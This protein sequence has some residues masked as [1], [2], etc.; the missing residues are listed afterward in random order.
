MP[1]R[2]LIQRSCRLWEWVIWGWMS[3]I[4]NSGRYIRN[5]HSECLIYISIVSWGGGGI[6]AFPSIP[7]MQYPCVTSNSLLSA[8]ANCKKESSWNL[9]DRKPRSEG[10]GMLFPRSLRVSSRSANADTIDSVAPGF[11]EDKPAPSI[12]SSQVGANGGYPVHTDCTRRLMECKG[13]GISEIRW[14]DVMLPSTGHPWL[15]S[16]LQRQRRSWRGNETWPLETEH[17]EM[18]RIDR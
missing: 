16:D 9:L 5:G 12:M 8:S 6:L 17:F 4:Q 13:Y 7:F 18:A 11:S 10:K 15:G 1:T 14:A 2:L 3:R